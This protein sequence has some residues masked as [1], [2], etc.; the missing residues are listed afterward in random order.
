[1]HSKKKTEKAIHCQK[2]SGAE[3]ILNI[4]SSVST[5]LSANRDRMRQTMF[6]KMSG[7]SDMTDFEPEILDEL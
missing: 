4:L 1:M 5:S 7:Y 2:I 3:L 6:E